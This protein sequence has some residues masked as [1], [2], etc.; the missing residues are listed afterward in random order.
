MYSSF[1]KFRETREIIDFGRQFDHICE[2]ILF[3]G[4][5]FDEFWLNHGLPVLIEGGAATEQEL[6]EGWNP[7][8]WDWKGLGQGVN[9]FFNP[10]AG[11]PQA[12]QPQTSP[13]Q[14]QA[15][16][17]P[18]GENPFGPGENPFASGSQQ[19]P[20]QA[21]LA[22]QKPQLSDVARQRADQAMKDVKLA[23]TDA[24]K[25]VIDKYKGDRDSVGFQ[26]ATGF[27]DKVNA[28]ADKLKINR[29]EGVFDTNKAFGPMSPEQIQ[30]KA[31]GTQTVNPQAPANLGTNTQ[32][33]NPNF[34]PSMF[35]QQTVMAPTFDP[36]KTHVPPVRTVGPTGWRSPNPQG[37]LKTAT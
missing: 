23:F 30:K 13:A 22:P 3:S 21:E 9:K 8:S 20:I 32:T 25:R 1:H 29:G 24:M 17:Q 12:A 35:G 6:L 15:T 26:L 27:M 28:Y 31:S 2:S 18:T 34:D 5:T 16:P 7:N 10:P 14:P 33:A 36:A 37:D 11:S 4:I 19:N